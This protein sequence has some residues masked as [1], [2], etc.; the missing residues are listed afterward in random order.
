MK[1]KLF[2]QYREGRINNE[3]FEDSSGQI[4]SDYMRKRISMDPKDY[5]AEIKNTD[6][7]FKKDNPELYLSH[8]KYMIEDMLKGDSHND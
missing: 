4:I 3:L 1:V 7:F 6:S 5:I 2:Y 8:R